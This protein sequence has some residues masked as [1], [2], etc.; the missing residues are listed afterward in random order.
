VVE[1][2]VNVPN[3]GPGT[4]P[5]RP[6]PAFA[7]RILLR[8]TDKPLPDEERVA[9]ERSIDQVLSDLDELRLLGAEAVVLDP[10]VGDPAQTARPETAWQALATVVAHRGLEKQ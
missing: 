6:V 8:L 7:P 4:D 9:G 5:G 3:F 1:L 2:G 10:F